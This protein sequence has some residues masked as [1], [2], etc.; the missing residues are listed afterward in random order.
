[1]PWYTTSLEIYAITT[2]AS[3]GIF[4]DIPLPPPCDASH[5]CSK[6]QFNLFGVPETGADILLGTINLN[7]AGNK[8]ATGAIDTGVPV[9]YEYLGDP[10]FRFSKITVGSADINQL[11]RSDDTLHLRQV[12]SL[13][14]CHSEVGW[15][16]VKDTTTGNILFNGCPEGDAASIVL[17]LTPPVT[18]TP[19][20]TPTPE[21]TP[22]PTAPPPP[23]PATLAPCQPSLHPKYIKPTALEEEYAKC[24]EETKKDI[25]SLTGIQIIDGEECIGDSLQKINNNF[26][27]LTKEYEGLLIDN[28]AQNYSCMFCYTSSGTTARSS[29]PYYPYGCETGH[30]AEKPLIRGGLWGQFYGTTSVY[31]EMTAGNFLPLPLTSPVQYTV[32]DIQTNI[33]KSGLIAIGY[34]SPPSTGTY[35]FYTES[36]DGSGVW[37]GDK[38]LGWSGR[39]GS[40]ALVNNGL[41]TAHAV[42]TVSGTIALT[43][44]IYYPIRIVYENK[45]GAGTF[46]FS[47]SGP[48][49]TRT[50]DLGSSFWY[51]GDDTWT[52]ETPVGGSDFRGN[53]GYPTTD[54]TSKYY[55]LWD[56]QR[57]A[58][59][60]PWQ[61]PEQLL[62][63][64]FYLKRDSQVIDSAPH[65][66]VN[67][68]QEPTTT[69]YYPL[70]YG[71]T[72]SVLLTSVYYDLT[73]VTE[74]TNHNIAPP[75]T[76]EINKP[77]WVEFTRLPELTYNPLAP[78]TIN[79]QY[80]F[81]NWYRFSHCAATGSTTP[82]Y[83]NHVDPSTGYW[84][85]DLATNSIN[86]TQNHTDATGIVSNTLYEDYELEATLTS[87][88]TDNDN[89]GIVLGFKTIDNVE[90]TLIAWRNGGGG[91]GGNQQ[92]SVRLNSFRDPAIAPTNTWT[93]LNTLSNPRN[94]EGAETTI[95]VVKK[96]GIITI[97]STD[98]NSTTYSSDSEI[99]I[100]LNAVPSLI[101]FKKSAIG[102]VVNEQLNSTWKN[103][104]FNP[105]AQ[106]TPEGII[107]V[108]NVT[109]V[110]LPSA[111]KNLLETTQIESSAC[112]ATAITNLN[113]NFNSLSAIVASLN[114][115]C[116]SNGGYGVGNPIDKNK[117]LTPP[118]P[119][120]PDLLDEP[121]V[122]ERESVL[123]RF[124]LQGEGGY[125]WN[126]FNFVDKDKVFTFQSYANTYF[127]GIIGGSPNNPTTESY[128]TYKYTQTIAGNTYYGLQNCL[129]IC[130]GNDN[131]SGI[132]RDGV[133]FTAGTRRYHKWIK[134]NLLD[135][136]DLF[137]P[138][139]Y[140]TKYIQALLTNDGKLYNL[141]LTDAPAVPVGDPLPTTT[142][143][144]QVMEGTRVNGTTKTLDDVTRFVAINQAHNSDMIVACADNTVWHVVV[145]SSLTPGDYQA[146]QI[147]NM[148]ASDILFAQIGDPG[149]SCFV[150]LK[151]DP[152]KL[153]RFVTSAGNIVS[154]DLSNSG[155]L[156][157][158]SPTPVDLS[159]FVYYGSNSTTLLE[160]GEFFMHGASNEFH[161]TFMTNKYI[162]T[163][164]AAYNG[165]YNGSSPLYKKYSYP[166]G[167]NPIR[168]S[169]STSY[170][171]VAEL[172]DGFYLLSSNG[173][174]S[175]NT[176]AGSGGEYYTAYQNMDKI[177]S[178]TDL[179][180]FL[181]PSRPDVPIFSNPCS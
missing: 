129:R 113:F 15:W 124:T 85:F 34:F 21:P 27:I 20:P 120:E 171:M 40:N 141:D 91:F 156:E 112:I 99:T 118:T 137:M 148:L 125:Q 169:T 84:A 28:C 172:S 56:Y 75:K 4:D 58:A 33:P 94:W 29:N 45:N 147:D 3:T 110:T 57:S 74:W 179:A 176:N 26:A 23:P 80:I 55:K 2:A 122:I 157:K 107:G 73:N 158:R 13:I 105:P 138:S 44:G 51:R 177:Q 93:P 59:T 69:P 119:N 52:T 162:H 178:W 161:Y 62:G 140:A 37:L 7:N 87:S 12:C 22:T 109:Y 19:T 126:T 97:N 96:N 131:I 90:Q 175:L 14:S 47:W 17:Q 16:V 132:F 146:R 115:C 128:N 174:A 163:F 50:T 168:M 149:D 41:G 159:P 150:V 83:P 102:F 166:A 36:K 181:A 89:V 76:A 92:W 180:L 95:K 65:L 101:P 133:V 164:K 30:E 100:D 43:A 160:P 155:W 77:L 127:P 86:Y 72:S 81:S 152:T 170:A 173:I 98:F 25:P 167:V 116:K 31:Y 117:N 136:K 103:I 49:I 108:G 39:T 111:T 134:D 82:C 53:L 64:D 70:H 42:A 60:I 144:P 130:A 142:I 46:E 66:R 10:T 11:V 78:K 121:C 114:N 153:Y 18:P 6:A 145:G 143:V 71:K 63:I 35:T 5:G 135:F 9:G 88:A 151:N 32:L 68:Y 139:S 61:S 165:T 54:S 123:D 67:V 48:G 106:P 8:S 24:M 38:A 154:R 1:M 104:K 79:S